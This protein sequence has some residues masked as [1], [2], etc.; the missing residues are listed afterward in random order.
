MILKN[1]SKLYFHSQQKPKGCTTN[2]I[3]ENKRHQQNIK[4][5]KAE[6]ISE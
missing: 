3:E 1:S 2:P 6:Q 4:H 5:D